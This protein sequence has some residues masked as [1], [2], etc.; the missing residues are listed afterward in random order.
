M[1]KIPILIILAF[2]ITLAPAPDMFAADLTSEELLLEI[3][4]H[5]ALIFKYLQ[6]ADRH[7][8]K[9]ALREALL[10][11]EYAGQTINDLE[12]M[13][14]PRLLIPEDH[15]LVAKTIAK[16]RTHIEDFVDVRIA[17]DLN[18]QSKKAS[19]AILGGWKDP[20]VSQREK[21]IFSYYQII[22]SSIDVAEGAL[23]HGDLAEAIFRIESARQAVAE[24]R[25]MSEQQDG[26]DG[27]DAVVIPSLQ[28][29]ETEIVM[30][31]VKVKRMAKIE[32]LRH[33]DI[34]RQLT[35]PPKEGI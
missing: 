9:K 21:E 5:D 18:V 28:N 7:Y 31:I 14:L 24:L 25:T 26:K 3:H 8:Q 22:V 2:V 32:A 23:I 35:K 11:A 30:L 6:T 17:L 29:L 34:M 20:G 33:V 4:I 27:G 10:F 16:Y 12:S 19:A 15:R 13:F 1:N